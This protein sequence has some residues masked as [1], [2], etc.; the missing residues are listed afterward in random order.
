MILLLDNYDSFTY[1]LVQVIA[2]NQ[3]ITVLRNDERTPEAAAALEPDALIISPGPG[4]PENAGY[5]EDYIRYF[6]GKIPILG[7]CLGHQAICEVFGAQINQAQKIMHGRQDTIALR[8]DAIFEGLPETIPVG[9]Y[10]SLAAAQDTIPQ[11]L[12]VIARAHDGEVMGVRHRTLP[13][14]GLQFHPESIM[15]PQGTTILENFLKQCAN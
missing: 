9:R 3:D 13:V 1:N 10:H 2:Q 14:W 5:C 15:T 6:A 7:I 12:E 11:T 8:T 4:R